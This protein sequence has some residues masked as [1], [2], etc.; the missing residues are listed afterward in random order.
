MRGRGVG[1]RRGHDLSRGQRRRGD[2]DI[3]EAVLHRCVWHHE[4]VE[5]DPE[6]LGVPLPVAN[7]VDEAECAA[8]AR[9]DPAGLYVVG[10]GQA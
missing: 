7:V 3:L 6:R 9:L 1:A 5:V 2:G 8:V 10:M 4:V